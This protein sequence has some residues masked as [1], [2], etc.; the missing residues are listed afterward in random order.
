[1][2]LDVL[3]DFHWKSQEV[4]VIDKSAVRYQ[5]ETHSKFV[6]KLDYGKAADY[7]EWL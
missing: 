2:V 4:P 5:Q 3:G 1:M 6:R 7:K